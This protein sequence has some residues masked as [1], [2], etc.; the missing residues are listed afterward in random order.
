MSLS[1]FLTILVAFSLLFGPPA[2]ERAMAAVPA[3]HHAQMSSESKVMASHCHSGQHD[4]TQ[5]APSEPCCAAMC[6]TAGIL[7]DAIIGEQLF[8]QLAAV[9]A[10]VRV[11]RGVLSEIVTPPP[12]TA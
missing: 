4:K 6:A 12:R 3:L 11:H 8:I 1:R 2:M 9:P 7:P 5:K 10:L